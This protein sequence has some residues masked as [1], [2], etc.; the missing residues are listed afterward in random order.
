[1]E[2]INKFCGSHP[3][4]LRPCLLLQP[5]LLEMFTW[6]DWKWNVNECNKLF[7]LTC[8]IKNQEGKL[9]QYTNFFIA[10]FKAMHMRVCVCASWSSWCQFNDRQH[11]NS[12]ACLPAWLLR[13][14]FDVVCGRAGVALATLLI[15]HVAGTFR[16]AAVCVRIRSQCAMSGQ[17][18]SVRQA[19][20]NAACLLLSLS[21]SLTLSAYLPLELR[22]DTVTVSLSSCTILNFR[23]HFCISWKN[24]D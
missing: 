24:H 10:T 3:C 8:D 4:Y 1:M 9:F 20:T 17:R 5:W 23:L 7:T 14:L 16:P 18:T 15:R 13:A 6:R 19:N 11:H 21:L 12:P 22:V 2:R